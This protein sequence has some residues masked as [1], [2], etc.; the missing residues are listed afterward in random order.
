MCAGL[1]AALAILLLL[2][3]SSTSFYSDIDEA[4]AGH[5]SAFLTLLGVAVFGVVIMSRW[6]VFVAA[7][8]AAVLG[9]LYYP[10]MVRG[11]IPGYLP[12]WIT[13]TL[14]LSTG[15]APPVIIGVLAAA[16]ALRSWEYGAHRVSLQAPERPDPP[17][18]RVGDQERSQSDLI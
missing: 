18:P 16:V 15:T 2:R 10:F 5:G 7:V 8:P 3:Y 14:L 12:S 17:N 4:R 9:L 1:A 6:S 11:S 13:D